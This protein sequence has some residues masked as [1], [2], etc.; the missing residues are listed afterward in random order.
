MIET[1][2]N[3]ESI[4]MTRQGYD[5]LMAELI[6]LRSE[7]RYRIAKR[8]EE[9]RS[10]GDLSEN[11]EYAAAKDE[12]SKLEGKIQSLEYQLN[13]AEVVDSSSLDGSLIAVGTQVTLMDQTYR[14]QFVYSIVNSKEA[15][16][17]EGRISSASP[18]GRAILN[19]HKG[20]EVIVKT[21]KGI[22][23]LKVLKIDVI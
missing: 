11:A 5:A 2:K 3:D 17:K 4:Q 22:R 20:D 19:R 1:K 15:N 8:I 7:E 9:A 14:K 10:F 21:P 13:R 23:K 18:V 16:P 6:H 12:Q